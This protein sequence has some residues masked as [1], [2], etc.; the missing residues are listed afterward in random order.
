MLNKLKKGC[1]VLA[2]SFSLFSCSSTNNKPL[3]IGFSADSAAIV[4]TNIDKDGLYQLK[5]DTTTDS[6]KSQL[7]SVVQ[8]PSDL[9]SAI[10]ESPIAGRVVVTD[11]SV[12]FI[13][14][15]A[16]VSGR[17]YLVSTYLNSRFASVG[18]VLKGRMS[19]SVKPSE[20][21]LHR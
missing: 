5:S 9:D 15:Q 2:V 17:D 6:L 21:L 10:M 18:N 16:L 19:Y 4:V 8:T 1:F 11:S 7:I 12:V 20:K 13:P 14:A 3:L